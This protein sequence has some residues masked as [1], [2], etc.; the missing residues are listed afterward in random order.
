[1]VKTLYFIDDKGLYIIDSLSG[2][3]Y[4]AKGIKDSIFF[5]GVTFNF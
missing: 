1:M 4:Y 5:S 2:I 3:K